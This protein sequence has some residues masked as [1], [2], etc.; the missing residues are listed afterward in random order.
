MPIEQEPDVGGPTSVD[1]VRC[2]L[3]SIVLDEH[4]NINQW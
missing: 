3:R 4:E 1:T 2:C